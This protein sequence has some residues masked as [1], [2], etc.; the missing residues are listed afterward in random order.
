[1]V[2]AETHEKLGRMAAEEP[3]R[4]AR[5]GLAFASAL[6]CGGVVGIS[7]A[8]A[9]PNDR[10]TT[11]LVFGLLVATPI[12]VGLVARGVH[13]DDRFARLLVVTGAMFSLTALSQSGN[14]VLYSVGRVA[15]WLVVPLLLF[16]MLSFP[17]GRLATRRDRRVMT[18]VGALALTLYL[19][20]ALLVDH[21]PEPSP[22]ARCDVDCPENAFAVVHV[23]PGFVDDFIRPVR[24]VLL[25][26]AVI[27]VAALLADRM[28]RSGPLCAGRYRRCSWSPSCRSSPSPPTSGAAAREPY[29][30]PWTS[31][32]GSGCSACPQLR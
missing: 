27:A 12:V 1:M 19:P 31:L 15:A 21:F 17:S 4:G 14:D 29:R 8:G 25:V 16:L 11:A 2:T 22:W 18:A 23:D 30:R 32:D 10:V 26:I 28:R 6:L 20:T 9:P 7:L 24:E 13:P 5:A 3:E